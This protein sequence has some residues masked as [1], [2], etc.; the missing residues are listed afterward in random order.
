[1]VDA[2][3]KRERVEESVSRS[4]SGMCIRCKLLGE[5]RMSR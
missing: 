4:V 5:I 3:A 2:N 1:M